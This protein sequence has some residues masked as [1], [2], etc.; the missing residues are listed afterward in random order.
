MTALPD[1]AGTPR[2]VK[3]GGKD[4][5]VSPITIDDLAEFETEVRKLRSESIKAMLK[6]TGLPDDVI[7]QKLVE[8]ASKSISIDD[9]QEAMTSMQGTRY[10]LWCA[11]RKH[12][13]E[14]KLEE[15]GNL[16]TLDN[17]DEATEILG[18]LG[19]KAVET[20][21]NARRGTKK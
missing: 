5:K 19:G 8:S 18:K 4:Y 12:Q 1:M 2:I 16:I 13:P 9:I 6:E 10:L 20:A 11:L 3:I 15:M 14:L 21:K 7:A 17:F